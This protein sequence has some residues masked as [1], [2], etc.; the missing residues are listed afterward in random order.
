M[1]QPLLHVSQVLRDISTPDDG[2]YSV[3]D[4]METRLTY[5]RWQMD[6]ILSDPTIKVSMLNKGTRLAHACSDDVSLRCFVSALRPRAAQLRVLASCIRP[7]RAVATPHWPTVLH[8][9]V[10]EQITRVYA[11]SDR[12]FIAGFSRTTLATCLSSTAAQQHEVSRV[13]RRSHSGGEAR[14]ACHQAPMGSQSANGICGIR[15]GY[16]SQLASTVPFSSRQRVLLC[17]SAQPQPHVEQPVSRSAGYRDG[18]CPGQ[19]HQHSYSGHLRPSLC[20]LRCLCV[21][22]MH[23]P[24]AEDNE[25]SSDNEEDDN[26]SSIT[27]PLWMKDRS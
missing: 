16:P 9:R 11:S 22:P 3:R 4:P 23:A 15:T 12:A 5:V 10:P 7:R 27:E 6:N 19:C 21:A 25:S 18:Q 13:V 24:C 14:T 8:S 26:D 20:P 17:C 2:L 1:C